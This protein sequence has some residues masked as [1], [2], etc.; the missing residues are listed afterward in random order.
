VVV[1]KLA[2]DS[3]VRRVFGKEGDVVRDTEAQ[4]VLVSHGLVITG[5]VVLSPLI[6]DLATVFGVTEVQAGLVIIVFSAAVMITI[7]FSGI[8]ADRVGYRW[9]VVPGL[10]VFGVAG[11]VIALVET[12]EAVLL[13]RV[14][15]GV[16]MAFSKP[17]LVAVLGVLYEGTRE[18]TAQGLRVAFD[19]VVS[20]G[21]PVLAAA[22]AASMSG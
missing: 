19:S 7:P 5:T 9:T 17:M 8:V 16:G 22:V 14:V 3:V 6:S 13:L 1:G 12:F 11:A 10:V 18:A 21:V 20:I 2:A 15:Q 4:V